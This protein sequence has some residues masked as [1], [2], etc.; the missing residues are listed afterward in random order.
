[1]NCNS[2]RSSRRAQTS[3]RAAF[4]S[5]SLRSASLRIFG[6]LPNTRR[7]AF[8]IA[9]NAIVNFIQKV[10]GSGSTSGLPPKSNRFYLGPCATFAPSFVKIR[11]M[12][13]E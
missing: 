2:H 10:L 6:L 1:M 7:G 5:F 3:D 9:N 11:W 12:G 8:T 4:N 13:F